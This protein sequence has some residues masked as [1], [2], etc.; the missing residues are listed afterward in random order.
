VRVL[1]V[2]PKLPD[3][4][5]SGATPTV[6]TMAS[7]ARQI[8]SLEAVGVE[9]EVLQIE[10]VPRLRYL[11]CYPRVVAR[12]R[13]ADVVHA[14]YGFS[15]WLAR[16]QLGRPVVTSFMGTD[17]LGVPRGDGSLKPASRFAVHANRRLA[18]LYDAVIVKSPEM[19]AA[20]APV[21]AHVVPN[22]VDLDAFAPVPRAEARARLGIDPG[23]R[24]VLFGGKPSNPRKGYPLAKAAVDRAA[25]LLGEPVELLVLEGVPASSVPLY[26]SA[27]EALVM[28]SL[29]E[30]SPN[31]VKEALASD[32]P[33]V[34]VPVGDVAFLLEDVRGS[35]VVERDE[36]AV[37][38][39]LAETLRAGAGSD[40]RAA[41]R[42]K[43]LD[44]TSVAQ[45]IVDIYRSVTHDRAR[46][47]QVGDEVAHPTG[48]T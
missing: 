32:L 3:L 9:A 45:R 12:S 20:V 44:S 42:R 19:A 40:G 6:A 16:G 29:I 37:G 23:R 22:G 10:G 11:Q 31:V 18:R 14:H 28:T 4:G 35:V 46:V 21:P 24:Y 34:A 17:V 27:S 1:M 5:A 7:V 38:A 47:P 48:R 30:G 2:T 25:A 26:M 8:R 15:G 43:G 39:A 36:E 41:L 13:A 33:V